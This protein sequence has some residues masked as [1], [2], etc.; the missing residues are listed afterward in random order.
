MKDAALSESLG[1]P[2]YEGSLDLWESYQDAHY[3]RRYRAQQAARPRPAKKP[4][5]WIKV[6]AHKRRRPGGHR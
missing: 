3:R 6:R 2:G 5:A 4:G 1:R